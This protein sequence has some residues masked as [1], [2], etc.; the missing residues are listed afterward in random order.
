MDLQTV[1]TNMYPKFVNFSDFERNEIK[2]ILF[3]ELGKYDI[4]EKEPCTDLANY[5]DDMKGYTM[6]FVAKKVEGLSPK[7]LTYYKFVIDNLLK[8][9]PKKIS[10]FIF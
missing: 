9:V 4:A 8:K 3:S 10:Q 2:S 5:S 1:W 7:S 6:F